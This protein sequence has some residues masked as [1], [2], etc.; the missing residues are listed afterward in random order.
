M[1]ASFDIRSHNP[2]LLEK[3][4]RIAVDFVKPYL[5]PDVVGIVF[6]GGI[7]RG[8]FDGSSDIDLGIFKKQGV[9]IG[10]KD[11]FLMMDGIEVQI[12][13]ED[14]ESEL[15]A[16]WDMPKRWTYSQG[17][18][19]FDPEG[20][21]KHLLED[22]V[23]LKAQERR[24]LLMEGLC[25][26]EWYIN[27]LTQLWVERGSLASAHHMLGTGLNYF[28]NMLFVLNHE[29][30]PDSKWKLYCA[31]RLP[32]LPDGFTAHMEAIMTMHDSSAAELERRR[33][34]FMTMWEQM[35]PLVEKEVGLS[36]NE[37]VQ[38]V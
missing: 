21:I 33:Q 35:K 31:G 23:P 1:P 22:K 30:I 15:T 4:K 3:A 24:E 38:L 5:I 18:I 34:A 27:R 7:A 6:L 28:L 26:S 9:D 20:K 37:I 29:L 32:K 2:V 17:L 10:L 25:L 12:W 14:Y 13:L 36:Y 16:A 19:H 11:K 8:Y